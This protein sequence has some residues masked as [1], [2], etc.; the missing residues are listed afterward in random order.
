M[1]I[2]YIQ[3]DSGFTLIEVMV[4]LLVSSVI[5]LGLAG[6]L[7][8]TIKTNR[9]SEERI[10]AATFASTIL[11]RIR[12]NTRNIPAYTQTNANNDALAILPT[13]SRFTPTVSVTP[14]TFIQGIGQVTVNI[15]WVDSSNTRN[16]TIQSEVVVP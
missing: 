2:L 15:A 10:L 8:T 16:V 1:S 9:V 12:V 4:S 11:E 5:L 14:A 7:L 6:M 13:G 3:R